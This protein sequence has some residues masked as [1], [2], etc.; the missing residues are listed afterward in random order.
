MIAL[1]RLAGPVAL[2]SE[3]PW[4]DVTVAIAA[5]NEQETIAQAVASVLAQQ[6]DGP[7]VR[8]LVGMDGCTD[9]T[10]EAVQSI[11]DPRVTA[12]AFPRAGKATTDNRLVAAASTAVVVTTSAGSEFAPG[13]LATLVAPFRDPRVGCVTG[14]F[15]P[16][17]DA[18]LSGEGERG[19]WG[20][21]AQVIDA[22]SRLGVLAVAS[23]TALAFR[24]DLFQ[25]IPAESDADVV[26]APTV[27]AQGRR[28]VFAPAA[29]V[30]DDG[31]PTNQSVLRNR[32]R[33]A[34]R[35]LPATVRMIPRLLRAGRPGPA[36]SLVAHKLCRWLTPFAAV[37]WAAMAGV[38][39]LRRDPVYEPAALVMVG[40]AVVLVIIA[41][42]AGRR[43][44]GMVTGLAIAQWAFAL[45]TIDA[46]RGRTAR[47]WTRGPESS[48]SA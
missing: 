47:T 32:R 36:A 44:R 19:Y 29:V 9:A 12:L 43:T 41:L 48:G 16:R 6:Y 31:P 13:T 18:A 4:P 45:A 35:A 40:A 46:L 7:P 20:L 23:G 15:R 26:I 33:M 21:E 3:S 17:M 1:G 30:Y 8:V 25:P 2:R 24:R 37:L 28:V 10:A 22:E 42:L 38:L 14:V 39:I 11:G 34:L 27:A 5:H